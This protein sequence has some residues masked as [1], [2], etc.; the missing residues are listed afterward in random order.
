M[1]FQQNFDFPY[2]FDQYPTSQ[3]PVSQPSYGNFAG[4]SVAPDPEVQ[5]GSDAYLPF[6]GASTKNTAPGVHFGVFDQQERPA[7]V[8]WP[9]TYHCGPST[10]Y[11][12]SSP[13]SG[14]TSWDRPTTTFTDTPS[15]AYAATSP[16][17]PDEASRH[18]TPSQHGSDDT[19]DL[20][21]ELEA[22]REA[23]KP[24]VRKGKTAKCSAASIDKLVRLV[25]EERPYNQSYGKKG[26]TWDTILDRLKQKHYF[27]DA[28]KSDTIKWKMNQLLDYHENG[29]T[30]DRAVAQDLTPVKAKAIGATLERIAEDR[31]EEAQEASGKK[32]KNKQIEEENQKG[33]KYLRDASKKTRVHP[34][35]DDLSDSENHP[36]MKKRKT[37]RAPRTSDSDLLQFLQES[38]KASMERSEAQLKQHGELVQAICRNTEAQQATARAVLDAIQGLGNAS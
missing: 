16:N 25:G 24:S 34:P 4:A 27:Q 10:T 32:A 37:S 18:S 30:L 11:D 9:E 6:D 36:P 17:V 3:Y 22:A 12:S 5:S 26:K 13:G 7:P 28:T 35:S 38:E 1:D 14:V 23:C 33:G 20:D 31:R 2:S 15:P 29:R 8:Q 19:D 21:A